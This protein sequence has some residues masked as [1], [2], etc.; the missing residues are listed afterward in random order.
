MNTQAVIRLVRDVAAVLAG[1]VYFR[2]IVVKRQQ[3]VADGRRKIRL[4]YSALKVLARPSVYTFTESAVRNAIYLWLVSRIVQLGANYATAWGVFN[5]IRWGLVMVPVQALHTSTLAFVGHRWGCFRASVE[6][7]AKSI[8]ERY[9]WYAETPTDYAL[10]ADANMTGIAKPAL[11][12]CC[13]ATIFEVLLCIALS[14][15]GIESFAY[16]LSASRT[17]AQITQTMGKAGST[18]TRETRTP[19]PRNIHIGADS[20]LGNRLDLRV[21]RTGLPACRHPSRNVTSV[22]LY[23]ALGSN[24]LWMLP[25]AIAATVVTLAKPLAWT[26]YAIIF[27][28]ALVFD[29]VVV[30]VTLA[31]WAFRLTKGKVGIGAVDRS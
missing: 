18:R 5:T 28:G 17:V 15:R 21:L 10:R 20:F 31:L 24:L 14:F 9:P 3:R 30:V 25:W 27:G 1:L 13:I 2:T 11:C 19:G 6:S 16:Y 7:E 8:L 29:V 12:S 26:Y 22:Y 23:Q 4:S